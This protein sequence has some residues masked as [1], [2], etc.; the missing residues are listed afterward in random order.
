M[1]GRL[2]EDLR[3]HGVEKHAG[4]AVHQLTLQRAILVT[5]VHRAI[6][7]DRHILRILERHRQRRHHTG[8]GDPADALVVFVGDQQ[9]A[10]GRASNPCRDIEPGRGPRAIDE[11]DLQCLA[12]DS[13]HHI[14]GRPVSNR[15]VGAVGQK[16]ASTVITHGAAKVTKACGGPGPVNRPRSG[17]RIARL[18]GQR[19]QDALGRHRGNRAF[20]RHHEGA[21]RRGRQP[22]NRGHCRH[23]R[24]RAR[25]TDPPEQRCRGGTI[26][27]VQ[28]A[29][30]HGEIT[31]TGERCRAARPVTGA[32][33]SGRPCQRGHG[34]IRSDPPDGAI[35]GINDKQRAR[36]VHHDVG[37]V[38]EARA[39]PGTIGT[40][41]LARRARKSRD[42][43]VGRDLPNH[44]AQLIRKTVA[45]G[46]RV[47]TFGHI[48]VAGPVR[49]DA[50]VGRKL[51]LGEWPIHK[52]LIDAGIQRQCATGRLAVD[53]HVGDQVQRA[54]RRDA[55]RAVECR[56]SRGHHTG[57]QPARVARDRL[58]HMDGPVGSADD[59]GGSHKLRVGGGAI[60]VPTRPIRLAGNHA[61]RVG[62]CVL[63]SRSQEPW[64]VRRPPHHH[65]HRSRQPKRVAPRVNRH[66][67]PP[68]WIV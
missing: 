41:E 22:S 24:H 66:R 46:K 64:D 52:A 18:A 55:H 28:S 26:Q 7:R 39:G 62:P 33:L 23:R 43:T 35:A 68:V 4:R 29:G 13:A 56:G 14:G 60:G 9:C 47:K 45:V 1:A 67:C 53:Q 8:C 40:A 30:R 49:R 57:L 5:H 31:R 25:K 58:S 27:Q 21:V 48:H 11:A 19:G 44:V 3:A 38:V 2:G 34:P 61:E 65:N 32:R 51:R 20:M 10:I 15:L 17:T 36:R 37:G 54:I 63:F 16:Q 42:L 59:R 6:R 50:A 12:G